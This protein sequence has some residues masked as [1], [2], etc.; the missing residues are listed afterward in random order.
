MHQVIQVSAEYAAIDIFTD[1][2]AVPPTATWVEQTSGTT[3]LLSCVNAVDNNI[4]WIGGGPAAGTGPGVILR[5]TN[6]GTTWT[7]VAGSTFTSQSVFAI[8]GI[9]ANT[10]LVATAPS[11]T[12]VYK[13]TNAGTNW[14][15]VYTAA[16]PGFVDD[17]KFLNS[18][19]I[20]LYGDPVGGRWELYKSTNSGSTWDSTGLYLP[21]TGSEAGWNNAL[22]TRG[23]TIWFGTN[24]TYVYYSTNA[25]AT[26]SWTL[27]LQPVMQTNIRLHLVIQALSGFCGEASAFISTNAGVNWTTLTA[28][29]TGT[30]QGFGNAYNYSIDEFGMEE[31]LIY[32]IQAIMAPLLLHNIYLQLL[33]LMMH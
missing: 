33:L 9:N 12:Y 15:Q 7:N 17:I 32:I 30:I 16:R 25:G 28:P 14:T 1:T 27:E 6:A 2:L 21:Q 31:E 11:A 5:T 19:T 8:C 29:G 24:N 23:N 20:F 13:T 22:C 3:Q 4:A 10:C 26:G 18:S